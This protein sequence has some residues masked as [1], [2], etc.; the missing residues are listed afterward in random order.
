[1]EGF[2]H[3]ANRREIGGHKPAFIGMTAKGEKRETEP[4][5]L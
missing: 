5:R 2:G 1:M 4:G 3:R